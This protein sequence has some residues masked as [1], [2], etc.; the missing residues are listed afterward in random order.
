MIKESNAPRHSRIISAAFVAAVVSLRFRALL[1]AILLASVAAGADAGAVKIDRITVTVADVARTEAFFR[2]ALGFETV[3][4][5]VSNDPA[6][7]RLL[8]VEDARLHVLTMRLGAETVDFVQFDRQGRPY[9]ANSKSPDLWFQHFAIIVSDMDKAY[10]RLM[11]FHPQVISVG[12]PQTLPPSTGSVE[13]FKFRD[14]DGHPLELLYFPPGQGRPVW[15]E[16]PDGRIFLG[17][18]HSAI[19]I[20]STPRS[21]DFYTRLLGLGVAYKSLNRGPTQESLDGTFNA[22]I[23]ITG[24]R[25]HNAPGPGIEFLDYRVPPTG[26][27]TPVDGE[28]ND[29][30]HVHLNIVV[31]DI[32]GLAKTLWDARVPFVSPGIVGL[33]TGEYGRAMM[34]RDPDGHA[35]MLMQ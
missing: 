25:P 11:R 10:Q 29:I 12:G 2:D 20:A 9:P 8:G 3:R 17:I 32:E 19:G 28:S 22:V 30:A 33:N 31:D 1:V 15:H 23:E 16:Q 26:R 18:D 5:V 7:A 14:P 6:L 35:L 24:I 13:S 4:Q 21:T 34:V 27:P